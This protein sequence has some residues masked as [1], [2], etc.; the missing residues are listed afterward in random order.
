M[1]SQNTKPKISPESTDTINLPEF[2]VPLLCNEKFNIDFLQLALT[3]TKNM[4]NRA[5]I[6]V[7]E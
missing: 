1:Q 2:E 5:I 6:K 3:L 7:L 4:D